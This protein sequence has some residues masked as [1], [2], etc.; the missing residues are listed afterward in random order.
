MIAQIDDPLVKYNIKFSREDSVFLTVSFMR[1]F[2]C[3]FTGIQISS[4]FKFLKT[5]NST[6]I[7]LTYC[8]LNIF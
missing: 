2:V 6:M 7:E 4:L 5:Y 3:R 1:I 8:I